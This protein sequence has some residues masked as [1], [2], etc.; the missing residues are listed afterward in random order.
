MKKNM[1][2][3]RILFIGIC[4]ILFVLSGCM[5]PD[6]QRRANQISPRESIILVQAAVD[7][8][9]ERTGVLPIKNFS[10]DASQ[11]ERYIIDFERLLGMNVLSSIPPIAFENGGTHYF[12]LV[13]V[14]EQPAVKLFD[15]VTV[16][17]VGRIENEIKS[18]A[19]KHQKLPFG[20]PIENGWY[21][22][23][24][25]ALGLENKPIRS[26]F[27]GQ[28]TGILIHHSGLVAVDYAFDIMQL[29]QRE[30]LTPSD[31]E[32]D[33]NKYLIDYSYYVPIYAPT[34]IW[35]HDRPI[36]APPQN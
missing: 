24:H 31:Q 11:Y 10:M 5:Y 35:D 3:F 28:N 30:Q 20:E 34:Y 29:I 32:E 8:Y 26:V 23:D 7:E 16:Q 15:L 17:A 9:F 12:V 27:S 18:Y 36:P 6:E 19:S 22:L 14:E 21:R 2:L 1:D 33:L 13:D 4:L 25:D